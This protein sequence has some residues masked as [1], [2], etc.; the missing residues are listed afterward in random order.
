MLVKGAQNVGKSIVISRT[1]KAVGES[2]QICSWLMALSLRLKSE[3]SQVR[4]GREICVLRHFINTIHITYCHHATTEWLYE[5]NLT[6]IH[7]LLHSAYREFIDYEY[8]ISCDGKLC[9]KPYSENHFERGI[10]VIVCDDLKICNNGQSG[11]KFLFPTYALNSFHS[12][13]FVR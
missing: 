12:Q 13:W 4:L 7:T 10:F 3:I 2:C 6:N 9:I 1:D 8:L 5:K 11:Y